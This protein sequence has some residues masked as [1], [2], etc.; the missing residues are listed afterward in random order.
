MAPSRVS[1]NTCTACRSAKVST[2]FCG[3]GGGY[4]Q[5]DEPCPLTPREGGVTPFSDADQCPPQQIRHTLTDSMRPRRAIVR[6]VSDTLGWR[7]G[8][9]VVC[10]LRKLKCG[11]ARHLGSPTRGAALDWSTGR[12]PP[13][14][15]LVMM[16]CMLSYNSRLIVVEGDSHPHLACPALTC[17]SPLT[18]LYSSSPSLLSPPD[19]GAPSWE[20]SVSSRCAPKDARASPQA[21][22]CPWTTLLL[23][24]PL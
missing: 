24:R 9:G 10:G 7:A 15:A 1:K 5:L 13:Q 3:V 21:R 23:R 18:S 22:R 16:K 6:Q 2:G 11:R 8:S 17:H 20:S 14:Q 4:G 12:L 19:L